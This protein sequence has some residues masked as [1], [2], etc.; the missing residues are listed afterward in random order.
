MQK[1]YTEDPILRHTY[2]KGPSSR[3]NRRIKVANN[4]IK[5]EDPPVN[6]LAKVGGQRAHQGFG[7]PQGSVDLGL[8]PI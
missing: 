6:T 7:Q 5:D 8:K 2:K 1:K 3:P 4:K